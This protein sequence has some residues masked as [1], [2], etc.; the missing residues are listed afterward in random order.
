MQE[1]LGN[2]AWEPYTRNAA[3]LL[4]RNHPTVLNYIKKKDRWKWN[5]YL[6][7]KGLLNK[8]DYTVSAGYDSAEEDL[9]LEERELV[10]NILA[11]F[12]EKRLELR[13]VQAYM[14]NHADENL[15]SPPFYQK[16]CVPFYQKVRAILNSDRDC[17]HRFRKNGS[18]TSVVERRERILHI[19]S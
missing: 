17:T 6:V 14:Q 7:I 19:T 8:F 11:K 9:D 1:Y 10:K 15:I 16:Y 12:R 2:A 5:Q 4:F 18:G 3:K 13:Q